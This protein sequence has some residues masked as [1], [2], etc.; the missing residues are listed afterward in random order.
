MTCSWRGLQHCAPDTPS[1][2]LL[3]ATPTSFPH[4]PFILPS[5]Q[6]YGF[7]TDHCVDTR[8]SNWAR[9]LVQVLV[10]HLSKAFAS[11]RCHQSPPGECWGPVWRTGHGGDKV[12]AVGMSCVML[13]DLRGKEQPLLCFRCCKDTASAV[14]V[15]G[16]PLTKLIHTRLSASPSTL[17]AASN[18]KVFSAL[19]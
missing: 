9:T 7:I 10:F 3:S 17:Q 6:P 16:L 8:K 13:P 1:P 18:R 4:F 15:L 5:H 19:P 2:V 11:V 12:W 14:I